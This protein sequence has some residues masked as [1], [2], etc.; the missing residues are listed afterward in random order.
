MPSNPLE[1]EKNTLKPLKWQKYLEINKMTKISWN[2]SNDQKSSETSKM[3][4][5]IPLKPLEILPKPQKWAKV[6]WHL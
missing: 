2:L 4:K 6:P 3:T 1:W 5:K